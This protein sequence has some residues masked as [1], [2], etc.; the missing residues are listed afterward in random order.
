[1]LKTEIYNKFCERTVSQPSKQGAV[2]AVEL[3]RSRRNF[4]KNIKNNL[5]RVFETQFGPVMNGLN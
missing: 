2:A 1:M 3:C 5:L 4:H